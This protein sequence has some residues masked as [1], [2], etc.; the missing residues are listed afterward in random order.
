M[1]LRQLR[2]FVAV[3]EELHFTRAAARVHMVQSSL[4]ASIRALEREVGA[5]LFV[6]DSRRVALTQAGR[7]LLPAARRA[8]AAADEGRDAVAGVRGVLR[9]QL[10]IGAIQTLGVIDLPAVLAAFRRAHPG[11]TIQLSHDAARELARAAGD[12]E[13]DIAFVDGPVDQ[14]RLRRFELGH[15]DL[16]LA[17]PR[18]DPLAK[19]ARI[20][21]SDPALRDRDFV[22]YRADSALRAQIDVACAAAGLARRTICEAQNMQYLAELVQHGLGVSVLPP[23]SLRAVTG[24][25]STVLITPPL[26]RDICVVIAAGRPPTGAAQALLDLLATTPGRP[27]S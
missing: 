22:D 16:V 4:S 2:H 23:M 24:Q 25:V 7:A 8:L 10:H 5:E 3:A 18:D 26:R 13:L 12:A 20:G 11:V 27:I 17:V 6:R 1:E 9:G 21:L 19:R 15:D 14:A